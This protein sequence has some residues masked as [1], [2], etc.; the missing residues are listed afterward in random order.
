MVIAVLF[1]YASYRLPAYPYATVDADLF[2]KS[3]GY[4]LLFLAILLF[5]QKRKG[6]EAV[7]SKDTAFLLLIALVML[8]YILLLEWIGFLISSI[9]FFILIARLLGYKRWRVNIITALLFSIIIYFSFNYLLQIQLPQG[10][11]PL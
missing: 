10:I 6:E 4:L 9:L 5:F 11:L 3:L 7:S 1:L 8:F 2:P